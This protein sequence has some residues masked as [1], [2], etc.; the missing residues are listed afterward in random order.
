MPDEPVSVAL[1]HRTPRVQVGVVP[2][3][4]D[5]SCLILPS[6]EGWEARPSRTVPLVRTPFW[7]GPPE[8][9]ACSG[10]ARPPSMRAPSRQASSP[11]DIKPGSTTPLAGGASRVDSMRFDFQFSSMVGG[12]TRSDPLPEVAVGAEVLPD[13]R[14]VSRTILS[15]S[16]RASHAA[17]LR[18][19]ASALTTRSLSTT[20]SEARS[21]QCC[22]RPCSATR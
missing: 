16:S 20:S 18:V 11:A 3:R 15:W 14:S 7:L 2:E 12:S 8:R 17:A 5:G 4:L 19:V 21:R 13:P 1:A 9:A 22:P 6:K 10:E